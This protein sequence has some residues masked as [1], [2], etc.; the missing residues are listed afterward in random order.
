MSQLLNRKKHNLKFIEKF[1]LQAPDLTQYHIRAG[2][3]NGSA[4]KFFNKH[5]ILFKD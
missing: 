2:T 3:K 5:L 4:N 1:A